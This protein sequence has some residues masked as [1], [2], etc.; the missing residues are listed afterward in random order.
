MIRASL[1]RKLA[2]SGGPWMRFSRSGDRTAY[3]VARDYGRI[4]TLAA[5]HCSSTIVQMDVNDYLAGISVATMEADDIA[6]WQ[7][8]ATTGSKVFATTTTPGGVTSTDAFTTVANQTP[9][10]YDAN[11]VALN[12]WKAVRRSGDVGHERDACGVR[13]KRCAGRWGQPGHPLT[14]VFEIAWLVESSHDSGTFYADGV[15]PGLT[16]IDGTHLASCGD[17]ERDGG[18]LI[19]ACCSDGPAKYPSYSWPNRPSI[20]WWKRACWK[21]CVHHDSNPQFRRENAD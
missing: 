13:H 9:S 21:R 11:R 17:P 8:I 7:Q 15:T 18:G 5:T 4:A 20:H 2:I 3:W 6:L 10:T 12:T 19:R 16:T 1:E 14:N